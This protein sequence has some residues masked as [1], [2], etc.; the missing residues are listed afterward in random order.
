LNFDRTQQSAVFWILLCLFF[1]FSLIFAT[2]YDAKNIAILQIQSFAMFFGFETS[3]KRLR[4]GAADIANPA[5]GRFAM[6]FAQ[7][8]PLDL[9]GEGARVGRHDRALDCGRGVSNS[10]ETCRNLSN[11]FASISAPDGGKISSARRYSGSFTEA[12]PSG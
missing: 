11:Y 9:T 12:V 7:V 1:L 5:F 2:G 10:V 8:K 6:F 3:S 4:E